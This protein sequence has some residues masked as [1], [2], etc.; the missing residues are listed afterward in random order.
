MLAALLLAVAAPVP[1]V[2]VYA[3]CQFTLD[4]AEYCPL[5][6]VAGENNPYCCGERFTPGPDEVPV[7]GVGCFDLFRG[8]T[9]CSVIVTAGS[10][11]WCCGV[12]EGV[13]D[14]DIENWLWGDDNPNIDLPWA[15]FR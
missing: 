10:A 15:H 1:R 14:E 11:A 9:P 6:V 12:D 2:T 13:D 8:A 3:D 4:S 5:L 7:V